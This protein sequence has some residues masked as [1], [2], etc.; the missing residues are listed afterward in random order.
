MI[1]NAVAVLSIKIAIGNIEYAGLSSKDI[2]LS[3]ITWLIKKYE[4]T[5]NYIYLKKAVWHVY[6]YLELGY[7]YKDKNLV[8]HFIIKA[9]EDED[10]QE[11]EKLNRANRGIRLNKTNIR[12]ILGRWNPKLHSMKIEHAVEDIIS[13]ATNREIGEYLYYAGKVLADNGQERLYEKTFKLYIKE[14]EIIL[15]DI[16]RNKYYELV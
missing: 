10:R 4:E 7:S 15:H 12:N 8:F 16:C 9:I 1:Y 14:N 13:K 3:S 2:L 11:I 5:K 6:A